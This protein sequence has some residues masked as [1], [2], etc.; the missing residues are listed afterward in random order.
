MG[1][2]RKIYQGRITAKRTVLP[3]SL[4][5]YLI[6]EEDG[7]RFLL[8][9][10]SNARAEELDGLRVRISQQGEHAKHLKRTE[11][12]FY[13]V[14]GASESEFVIGEKIPLRSA[15]E[16]VSVELLS[17]KYGSYSY[18][19]KGEELCVDYAR[20]EREREAKINRLREGLQG[21]RTKVTPRRFRAPVLVSVM[22]GLVLAC[23]IAL[24]IVQLLE[25]KESW[26]EYPRREGTYHFEYGDLYYRFV[27][28]KGDGAPVYICGYN[29]R[30]SEVRIPASVEGHPVLEV[31]AGAFHDES[32]LSKVT[33]EGNVP[34]RDSAFENCYNLNEV[35]LGAVETIGKDAF[36]NTGVTAIT[37]S[38]LQKIGDGAFAGCQLLSTVKL[39][40]EEDTLYLGNGAFEGCYSLATFSLA[41]M[42]EYG[43]G[44]RGLSTVLSGCNGLKTV[45]LA[46]YNYLP[47]KGVEYRTLHDLLPDSPLLEQVEIGTLGSLP[48]SF[49]ADYDM[50]SFSVRKLLEE[51]TE[52]YERTFYGCGNLREVS[53]PVQPVAIDDYCFYGCGLESY[54]LKGVRSVGD[55][56]FQRCENLKSLSLT[57]E[58][59]LSSVGVGAFGGTGLESISIPH[60]LN[61]IPEG[62]FSNCTSLSEVD[63]APD[64]TLHYI[65]AA[66]FSDC[67]SLTEFTLPNGLKQ[68]GDRAFSGCSGLKKLTVPNSVEQ[69]GFDLLANSAIEELS[70]PFVGTTRGEGSVLSYFFNGEEIKTLSKVTVTDDGDLQAFA[71]TG[72]PSLRE[73]EL[74]GKVETIGEQAFARCTGLSEISLPEG[75][76]KVAREAFSGCNALRRVSL[77]KSLIRVEDSAFTGCYHLYELRNQS[78]VSVSLETLL[79][80]YSDEKDAMPEVEQD[81]YIFSLSKKGWY[82]TAYPHGEVALSLP[83]Q[84]LY[85][86]SAV[87]EYQIPLYLMQA[88]AV[89][90]VKIPAA[91][92]AIGRSAFESCVS[93]KKVE[94]NSGSP[95]TEIPAR[96]FHRCSA[97][98]EIALPHTVKTVGEHAFSYCQLKGLSLQGDLR[99]ICA[100]AF[101]YNL[102]LKEVSFGERL[103]SVNA[104]AFRGC[105]LEKLRLP[106]SLRTIAEGAFME[107]ATLREVVLDESVAEIRAGAFYGCTKLYEVFDLCGLE[108]VQGSTEHGGVAQYAYAVYTALNESR[109]VVE[110][111][112]NLFVKNSEWILVQ[113]A[114]QSGVHRFPEGFPHAD[115]EVNAYLLPMELFQQVLGYNGVIVPTAVSG[116]IPSGSS[117]YSGTVYYCGSSTQWDLLTEGLRFYG[118]TYFYADCPHADD[119]WTLENDQIVTKYAFW[120]V[121]KEAT[122]TEKGEM[123][124]VCERCEKTL[125]TQAITELGHQESTRYVVTVEATCTEKGEKELRCRRCEHVMQT[126]E[127]PALGH[128]PSS[129]PTVTVPATCTVEGE[130]EYPCTRCGGLAE[131]VSVEKSPHAL[132]AD[133]KCTAC[134]FTLDGA[135]VSVENESETPF[136]RSGGRFSL[137]SASEASTVAFVAQKHNFVVFTCSAE[138]GVLT[139]KVNGITY[140]TWSFT[141]DGGGQSFSYNLS[142]GDRLSFT[143]TPNGSESSVKIQ[144]QSVLERQD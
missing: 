135:S 29:G 41:C 55:Y 37:S 137:Q 70:V 35:D 106:T 72:V 132:G 122:C 31:A 88:S 127:V 140:Y 44:D 126:V 99:E 93:L 64:G 131:T 19:Q 77:P 32:F 34:V 20:G 60:T 50:T 10:G 115:G 138:S 98:T 116:L 129:T 69:I 143:F 78:G 100:Q 36:K 6:V 61:R 105:A 7:K 96:C 110:H 63:F 39:S 82:M 76:K 123:R 130:A 25:Y 43:T 45:S 49:A 66:A 38:S 26:H 90:T 83:R 12:S 95:I 118:Y 21:A 2:Q 73:V 24:P 52:L 27:S 119:E 62:A 103:Q 92:T 28:G 1:E 125:E 109:R 113:T 87:T 16:R 89:E 111:E 46:N 18:S 134:E 104:Y 136:E 13:E 5:E 48:A 91:V 80:V 124:C 53:I 54:D 86:G 128:R 15:C 85:E 8:L 57:R 65:A 84:F 33:F 94:I 42:T 17:V 11:H 102:G 47:S 51:Q 3:V 59:L 101:E 68:L 23:L 133:G 97:L 81:G 9:K 4:T 75:V 107:N 14:H 71:F 74:L 40:L 67:T 56:A 117:Y 30:A 112:G 114:L 121:V 22:A 58:S 142:A 120:S 141:E 79:N 144:I 108:I 139:V